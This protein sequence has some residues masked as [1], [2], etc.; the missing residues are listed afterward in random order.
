MDAET[1]FRLIDQYFSYSGHPILKKR[2]SVIYRIYSVI[3]FLLAYGCWL[4]EYIECLHHLDDLAEMQNAARIA[5]PLTAC[6]G[7][8][9]FVRLAHLC[10]FTT[11]TPQYPEIRVIDLNREGSNS[12]VLIHYFIPSLQEMEG[13]YVTRRKVEGSK[14]DE[15]ND[16]FLFT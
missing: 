8:D 2:K 9:L 10:A 13:H 3:A 15:V 4:G 6:Y 16:F 11:G 7:M 5:I 14:P 12:G 1:R